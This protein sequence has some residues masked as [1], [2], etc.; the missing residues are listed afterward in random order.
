[1]EFRPHKLFRQRRFASIAAARGLG[2]GPVSPTAQDFTVEWHTIDG[3]GEGLSETADQQWQLS[4]TIGQPDAI[5]RA[6]NQFSLTTPG[7][8]STRS[9]EKGDLR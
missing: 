5:V 2:P 3:G 6:P 9:V 7:A 8:N 1:M 4:G